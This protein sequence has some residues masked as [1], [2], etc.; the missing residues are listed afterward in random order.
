MNAIYAGE[1]WT[2]IDDGQGLT[3]RREGQE[4]RFV[5][6]STPSLIIDPPDAEVAAAEA[7]AEVVR[8]A[9]EL[10]MRVKA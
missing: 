2:I 9:H 6:F 5:L 4:D 10:I 1:I 3:L 7:Q 8:S